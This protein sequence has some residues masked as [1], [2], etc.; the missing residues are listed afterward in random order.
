MLQQRLLTLDRLGW[1]LLV[2]YPLVAAELAVHCDLL[3]WRI[4]DLRIQQRSTVFKAIIPTSVNPHSEAR[5]VKA[6]QQLDEA[7]AVA[8]A[9]GLAAGVEYVKIGR[10][11]LWMSTDMG[12]ARRAVEGAIEGFER[13]GAGESSDAMMMRFLFMIMLMESGDHQDALTLIDRDLDRFREHIA[14][15]G[16]MRGVKTAILTFRGRTDEAEATL[17]P[18]AQRLEGE[19]TSGLTCMLVLTG[20][21]ILLAQGRFEAVFAQCDALEETL[22]NTGILDSIFTRT[23]M[24]FTRLEAALGLDRPAGRHDEAAIQ[25]RRRRQER[26]D[27]VAA[28]HDLSRSGSDRTR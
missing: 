24:S 14:V 7:E 19:P 11:I 15:Q 12:R 4:G 2:A 3:G 16:M 10:G 23:L 17:A 28:R 13:L 25:N 26:C 21:R 8:L 22:H 5:L 1:S 6:R 27:Q 18:L 9:K 20:V